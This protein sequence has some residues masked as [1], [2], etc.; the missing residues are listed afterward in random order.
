MM[1]I[2]YISAFNKMNNPSYI[3]YFKAPISGRGNNDINNKFR[4]TVLKN[5]HTFDESFYDDPEYGDDWINFVFKFR[6]ALRLIC[7]SYH[8]YKIEHKAGRKYNY[9]YLFTFFDESNNKICDE[10]I[11]FK[12]NASCISDTPQFVSPMNP[13]KYLSQSFEEYHYDK[14]FKQFLEE[15]NFPVPERNEYISKVGNN[16]PECVRGPQELYYQGAKG[17]SRYTGEKTAVDFY[18]KCSAM[19]KQSITNF[20]DETDLNIEALTQ[21]LIDSQNNKIY[22]LYKN[23][24]F[25]IQ[26]TNNDDYII[27]SYTKNANKSIYQ[28]VTKTG[29]KMKIL[30]RWKNGNGIAYP[31]FQIS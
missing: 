20:I 15:N 1:L 24:V 4:E 9:D 17:S 10:K 27:E 16:E 8:S 26:R 3:K 18:K 21:Y 5:M 29:K 11:E 2:Y 31:A 19:S 7:P 23:G 25:N 30:L 6:K 13:S 22:L 28:A 12:Y 14:Y